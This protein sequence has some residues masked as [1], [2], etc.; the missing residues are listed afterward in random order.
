MAAQLEVNASTGGCS[1]KGIKA[2]TEMTE[3]WAA[4]EKAFESIC[5]E[6]LQK[7]EVKGFDDVQRM[8][9][10]ATTASYGI[11]AE[12]R[13]KWKKARSVGFESL[14]YLKLLV[15]AA[16]LATSTVCCIPRSWLDGR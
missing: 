15:V 4:A 2:M 11:D 9:E 16:S 10:K 3:M 1:P 7:G 5:H 12:E 13:D 14:K 6:S 8:I